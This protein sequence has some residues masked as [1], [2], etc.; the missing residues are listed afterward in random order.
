M[1]CRFQIKGTNEWID[2]KTLMKKLNEGL[3]DKYIA[4]G[5]VK[6]QSFKSLLKTPNE[7]KIAFHG[8]NLSEG[9]KG[10]LYISEEE[11]QAKEYA[12]GNEGEVNKIDVTDLNI[13]D[14]N[15]VYEIIKE[16]GFQPKDGE[17]SVD[18]LNLFEL[19]DPRFETSLSDEDLSKLGEILADK[20]IDAVRFTDTN[21]KTLKQDVE[22]IAVFNT[23][24]VKLAEEEVTL[25]DV[26]TLDTTDATNLQ[27][28]L[29]FIESIEND[30]DNFGKGTLGMNLPVAVAKAV[31]KSIK[32]L[33]QAGVTLEQA[34]KQ[35]AVDNNVTEQDIMD[36]MVAVQA[37]Q[38][39]Q[40]KVRAKVTGQKTPKV[41]PAAKAAKAIT[42]KPAPKKVTVNEMEALKDQIRLE[43]RAARGAK[44]NI[45][46]NIKKIST[47]IKS[48]VTKG[49]IKQRHLKYIFNKLAA[50]NLTNDESVDKLLDYIFNKMTDVNYLNK[51]DEIAKINKAIKNNKSMV[52]PIASTAKEFA[53]INPALVGNIDTHL[54]LAKKIKESLTRYTKETDP[55]GIEFRKNFDYNSLYKYVEDNKDKILKKAK[56]ELSDI[57]DAIFGVNSSNGKSDEDMVKEIKDAKKDELDN[58]KS[59]VQKKISSLKAI[60]ENDPAV[61][62]LVK[63]AAEID[64]D[65]LNLSDAV[66][67]VNS[68]TM[69]LDNGFETGLNKLVANYE[70]AK[71]I[72][73]SKLQFA[74]IGVVRPG[75]RAAR[76]Y[77]NLFNYI[78]SMLEKKSKIIGSVERLLRESGL[79]DVF[80]GYNRSE[81]ETNKKRKEYETK[82]KKAKNFLSAENKAERKVLAEVQ[83]NVTNNKG[84][85]AEF[86]R[87]KD[88]VLVS[89]NNLREAAGKEN[90][91]IADLQEEAAKKL[92]VLNPDG[93]VN[94]SITIDEILNNA[95]PINVEGLKWMQDMWAD[96]Y[97]RLYNH[98]LGMHNTLLDKDEFYTPGKYSLIDKTIPSDV[99]EMDFVNFTGM[100]VNKSGVL[101]KATSPKGLKNRFIPMDFEEDNF[102][103]YKAALN[104]LYTAEARTKYKAYQASSKFDDIMGRDKYN[105][106]K[107]AELIRNAYKRYIMAKENKGLSDDE[108]NVAIRKTLNK[109]S[110]VVGALTLGSV[111]NM[112]AQTIPTYL[113]TIISAGPISSV[114]IFKD[115]LDPKIWKFIAKT[116]SQVANRGKDAIKFTEKIQEQVMKKSK[117]AEIAK[118]PFNAVAWTSEQILKYTNQQGD[119]LAAIGVYMTYYRKY[120]R[121]NGIKVDLNNVNKDAAQYAETKTKVQILPSDAAERGKIGADNSLSMSIIRQVFFPYSSFSINQKNR[122]YGDLAKIARGEWKLKGEAFQDLVGATTGLA[123]FQAVNVTW[124]YL[125]VQAVVSSL[126]GDDEDDEELKKV[127]NNSLKIAASQG[128]TDVFSPVPFA[129]PLIT[130]A[131]NL[132]LGDEE[133]NMF[134]PSEDKWLIK[135]DEIN[136]AREDQGKEPLDE[137]QIEKR[138][139]KFFEEEEWKLFEDENVKFLDK[140]GVYGM[141]IQKSLELRDMI[142][143][144]KT[145]KYEQDYKGNITE[146]TLTKEGKEKIKNLIM[147]KSL[148]LITGSADLS[149]ISQ[150]A[151]YKVGKKNSLT[152]TQV[153]NTEEVKEWAKEYDHKFDKYA[154]QVIKI[155]KSAKEVKRAIM[156]MEDLSPKEKEEY[157]KTLNTD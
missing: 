104:D 153:S 2:D 117:A 124:K 65:Y 71:A 91:A 4:S 38:A 116:D 7:R 141:S 148:G 108:Q 83:R 39:T 75:R 145:G 56:K 77:N 143:A 50:T 36:T 92:G 48:M 35:A 151:F 93:T 37:N 86:Q 106:S 28:V 118:A 15:T 123:A 41:S 144:Y 72:S 31:I 20:G 58:I 25:D 157:I 29:G 53:K 140:F 109:I 147:L 128:L 98:A 99:D 149:N 101:M 68:I 137:D 1:S 81:N 54:A 114:R 55:L 126:A 70:G 113:D 79:G 131:A 132:I 110:S 94:N 19:I 33:L 133:N 139:K 74:Q 154:E 6:L 12:K 89:I 78:E 18:E 95:D 23:S 43:A 107:D 87:R 130:G 61:S 121:K 146:K 105:K 125:V 90:N 8:G 102:G 136:Q 60:V 84:K 46:E 45:K 3:L 66:D 97:D 5:E 111:K 59:I 64:V 67:I 34:I 138:R 14:E 88:L 22:N 134:A 47:L 76:G 51:L 103:A 10:V 119:K 80:K 24:K 62:D 40:N 122:I 49:N 96:I 152:D 112:V 85:P 57:Y 52:E 26:K 127:L 9:I 156:H 129:D 73:D 32:V 115:S 30:L 13:A 155:K 142:K 63:K 11:D 69:Y 27:K 120:C 100:T 16:T 82:F 21:L 17:Y 42:K 44:A 150:K 135:L